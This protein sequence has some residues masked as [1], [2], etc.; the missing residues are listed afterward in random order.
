MARVCV[1]QNGQVAGFCKYGSDNLRTTNS[2]EFLDKLNDYKL[3]KQ[4]R[5]FQKT[6]LEALFHCR[7]YHILSTFLF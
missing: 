6:I 4:G 7:S 1:A 2:G 3:L 5:V